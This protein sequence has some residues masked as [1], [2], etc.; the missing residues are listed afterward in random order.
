[1][2]TGSF[3]GYYFAFVFL[4]LVFLPALVDSSLLLSVHGALAVVAH[5]FIIQTVTTAS[6]GLWGPASPYWT[7][8]IEVMFYIGCLGWSGCSTVGGRGGPWR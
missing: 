8:T 5:G 2:L 3:R 1:M 4:V 6:Y 7:L